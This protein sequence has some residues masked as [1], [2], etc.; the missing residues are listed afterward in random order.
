MSMFV[1]NLSDLSTTLRELTRKNVTFRWS[2]EHKE[3]FEA[4]KE[5]VSVE[6]T[7]NY[8]DPQKPITL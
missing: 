7:L 2:D 5:A 1:Q 8:F 4:N 3:A 6:V